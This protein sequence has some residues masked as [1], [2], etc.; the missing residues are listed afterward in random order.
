M[1]YEIGLPT[2]HLLW[3]NKLDVLDLFF[4]MVELSQ[5]M[6]FVMFELSYLRVVPTNLGKPIAIVAGTCSVNL[7]L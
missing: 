4:W 5:N 6:L 3:Y 7:P 2:L 1:V